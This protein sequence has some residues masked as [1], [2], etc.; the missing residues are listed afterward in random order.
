MKL[1]A[2]KVGQQLNVTAQSKKERVGKLTHPITFKDYKANASDLN[3]AVGY[4]F[5][6]AKKRGQPFLA[7]PGNSYGV[8]IWRVD[9]GTNPADTIWKNTAV[10]PRAGFEYYQ[11]DPDGTVFRMTW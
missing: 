3:Y 11:V 8:A 1:A 7:M 2:M 4:A 5:S 6:L 9:V 10:K